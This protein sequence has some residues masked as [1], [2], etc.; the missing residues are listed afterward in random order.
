MA[1]QVIR[2]TPHSACGGEGVVSG[3]VGCH[4]LDLFGE[5]AGLMEGLGG[6]LAGLVKL[7]SDF[8]GG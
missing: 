6:S 5:W 2:W 3:V 7:V 8:K 1:G 4:G